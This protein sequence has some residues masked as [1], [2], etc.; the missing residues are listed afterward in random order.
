MGA[1]DGISVLTQCQFLDQASQS[2][3]YVHVVCARTL[4]GV[5]LSP[6]TPILLGGL[7]AE[8]WGTKVSWVVGR[9]CL[10]EWGRSARQAAIRRPMT[11]SY[12]G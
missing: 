11:A 9:A 12:T 7:Y 2:G 6:D 5:L 4:P 10:S 1:L 3:W 8:E